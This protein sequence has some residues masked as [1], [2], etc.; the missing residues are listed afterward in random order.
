MPTSLFV[1][2]ADDIRRAGVTSLP[3][4][5]R[6]A[7]NLQVAR[8]NNNGYA[9]SAR[10]FNNASSDKLLVL[11]DGRAVYS[12][13]FS[14]VFWDVQDLPLEDIE[15]IEVISGPG[16]TVWGVNAVNGVINV[17]TRSSANTQGG[18]AAG[19]A[20]PREGVATLRWGGH[21]EGSADMRPSGDWRAW[22]RHRGPRRTPRPPMARR[23]DDAPRTSR[24]SASAIRLA[25]RSRPLHPERRGLRRATTDSPRPARSPSPACPSCSATSRPAART[26][27]A[28]GRARRGRR[29]RSS[30]RQAVFDSSPRA[31]TPRNSPTARRSPTCS[32]TSRAR[33]AASTSW[34]G[35]PS[36]GTAPKTRHARRTPYFAF[37][38]ERLQQTWAARL[39]RR[40]RSALGD[41]WRATAGVRLEHN[42]YTGEDWL[43]SLRLHWQPDA[44]TLAWAAA[45]RTVRAPSRFDRDVYVPASPP[46]L[47]AGGPAFRSETAEVYELGYR[48]QPVPTLS[49]S[50]T[51]YAR[52]CYEHLHSQEVDPSLTFLTFANGP[53]GRHV[54][55]S[56]PGPPG[57][58]RR[59]GACTPGFNHLAMHLE[60]T[61]LAEQRHDFGRVDG[62]GANPSRWWS[63]LRTSVDFPH[64]VQL[65]AT[66]RHTSSLA[67][68]YVPAYS[69]LD[70]R[71]SPGSPRRAGSLSPGRPPTSA[72]ADHA[73]F[74]A[75]RGALGVRA[76]TWL[77][78]LETRI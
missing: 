57:R 36:C 69:A 58:P 72:G 9:I 45:S 28:C 6:L 53:A 27:T 19:A 1:I 76:H 24:S 11:I 13:L 15:R 37:L 75:A 30:P 5:L 32:S 74:G 46:F 61:G 39:L 33:R 62:E 17:I 55:A 4:A 56:R 26:S 54:A 18:L 68:P 60:A 8:Q 63:L 23:V 51:L 31:A 49:L 44:R 50:A 65:D 35:A 14:G 38:P 77:L 48:G 3:E 25:G 21:L 10:G 66:L 40:I 59:G 7:P 71:A 41:R 2:T 16:G 20:G 78:A 64:R 70:A 73:E 67:Q 47:L 43:P 34:S 12:P 29:R 42:D 22:A 52:A